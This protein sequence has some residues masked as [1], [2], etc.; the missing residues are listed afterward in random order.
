MMAPDKG[1]LTGYA[2]NMRMLT[3]VLSNI[4]RKPVVDQTGHEASFDMK[5][6]FKPDNFIGGPGGPPAGEAP[7]AE[8]EGASIFTALTEQLGLKLE[9]KKGP[10]L[11]YLVE[12]VSKPEE[13]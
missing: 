3:N 1:D 8:I 2:I 7:P 11:V 6:H 13:N 12:K 4:L 10:V 5:L 9:S